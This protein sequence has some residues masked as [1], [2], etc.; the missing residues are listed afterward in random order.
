MRSISTY[1]LVRRFV[2]GSTRSLKV[3]QPASTVLGNTK[4]SR[5]AA[6]WFAFTHLM[7]PHDPISSGPTTAWDLVGQEVPDHTQMV[8]DENLIDYLKRVYAARSPLWTR[9]SEPLTG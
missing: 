9:T 3:Y 2:S 7:E 5:S 8:G 4:T 6:R 1:Q